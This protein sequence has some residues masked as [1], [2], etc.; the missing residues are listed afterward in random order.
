MS[1][2]VEQSIENVEKQIGEKSEAQ[3]EAELRAQVDKKIDII[4]KK[5]VNK[6]GPIAQQYEDTA[7]KVAK[8]FILNIPII[9]EGY[10]AILDFLDTFDVFVDNLEPNLESALLLLQLLNLMLHV[11]K[12]RGKQNVSIPEG[13]LELLDKLLSG[14][15]SDT[16]KKNLQMMLD[17]MKKLRDMEETVTNNVEKTVN[18]GLTS[19]ENTINQRLTSVQE[20]NQRAADEISKKIDQS[21]KTAKEKVEQVT[22]KTNKSFEGEVNMPSQNIGTINSSVPNKNKLSDKK[23]DYTNNPNILSI[24]NSRPNFITT[25]GRKKRISTRT[26]RIKRGTRRSPLVKTKVVKRSTRRRARRSMRA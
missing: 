25:G 9:G 3:I 13:S 19:V 7:K 23:I 16:K 15:L 8:R 5:L 12:E 17:K 10:A 11:D 22:D 18:T 14:T 4:V 6:F 2:P 1:E 24:Q 26:R 20:N 21:S